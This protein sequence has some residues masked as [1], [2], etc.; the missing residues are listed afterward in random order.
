[1]FKD[2]PTRHCVS[3]DPAAPALYLWPDQGSAPIREQ[4]AKDLAARSLGGRTKDFSILRHANG[5]P[6]LHG[7][8]SALDISWSWRPGIMVAA[9]THR[10]IIGVDVE[11]LD[12]T[13]PDDYQVAS[14]FFKPAE[15]DWI[16]RDPKRFLTVWTGHEAMA[17]ALGT[18]ISAGMG[19]SV[20]CPGEQDRLDLTAQGSCWSLHWQSLPVNGR[21]ALICLACAPRPQ[22]V[23]A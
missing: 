2:E 13:G 8:L 1:M 18:G 20:I 19:E 5:K 12:F 22:K 7:T 14:H 6:A 10:G 11:W 21:L 17:K 3:A 16:G 9:L 15:R 23:A 4:R